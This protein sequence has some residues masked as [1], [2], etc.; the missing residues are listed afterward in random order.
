VRR[1]RRLHGGAQRIAAVD[2]AGHW[3]PS[4]LKNEVE[5]RYPLEV[6]GELGGAH[7]M[8]IGFPRERGI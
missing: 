1:L 5:L 4:R 7:L 8:V 2:R 6:A 3:V